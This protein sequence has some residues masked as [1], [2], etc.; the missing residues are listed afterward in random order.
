MAET[1]EFFGLQKEMPDL[2]VR[3]CEQKAQLPA[4]WRIRKLAA[5]HLVAQPRLLHLEQLA[6]LVWREQLKITG[7]YRRR[8][9]HHILAASCCQ[10]RM[11]LRC[12]RASCPDQK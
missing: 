9:G 7:V 10:W 12:Q 2:L 8:H 1:L 11:P 3:W 5:L 4:Q 6:E